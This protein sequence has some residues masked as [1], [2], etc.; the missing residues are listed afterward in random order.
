MA[1]KWLKNLCYP[2]L[3]MSCLLSIA[4]SFYWELNV[5]LV[6]VV[7]LIFCIAYLALF[8]HL[9]PY[10]ISWQA[11]A[12]EWR[13][14]GVY[15]FITMLG[16]GLAVAA[17]HAIAANFAPH[18]SILPLSVEISA[19]LLLSSLGSYVF[20][21]FT[22]VQPWMWLIHGIH[23]VEKK[24]NV[25]NNG[26]NHILDVFGRRLLAQL[27][28]IMFGFSEQAIF[29]VAM[30]NTL[31]GYFVHAN[32]DVS[33]GWFNYLVVSPEQHRLHHSKDLSEAGHYSVDIPLWDMVFRSFTWRKGRR[34][35]LIGVVNE[36]K[37]MA[38]DDIVGSMLNPWRQV[39][40]KQA[41]HRR[42]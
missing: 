30:F 17:V 1:K 26:V 31:Q 40:E 6:N 2:L 19:T 11:S 3:F 41:L 9:I 39:G 14:D 36:K 25:G 27:P 4:A 37:F 8:E 38:P 21:R 34:P 35:I 24:V 22:H 28:L 18:K 33:L 15:L 5:G 42:A 12:K 13:R 7:F 20:H 10:E 32:I 16:G 23:H 29:V